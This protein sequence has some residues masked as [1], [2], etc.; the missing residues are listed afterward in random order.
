MGEPTKPREDESVFPLKGDFGVYR[1]QRRPA[2]TALQF[3]TAAHL[4][5]SLREV[6]SEDVFRTVRRTFPFD[7]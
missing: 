2:P 6:Q 1:P 5:Q 4:E 7:A 3:P